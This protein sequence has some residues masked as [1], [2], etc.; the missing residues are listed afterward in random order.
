MKNISSDD[1]RAIESS[2]AFIEHIQNDIEGIKEDIEG[3][4][5]RIIEGVITRDLIPR[6]TERKEVLSQKI[7]ELQNKIGSLELSSDIEKYIE[8]MPSIIRKI[9]ELTSKPF[10]EKDFSRNYSEILKLIDITCGELTLTKEKALKI[11]LFEVLERLKEMENLNWQDD[12]L[13]LANFIENY[14]KV[15]ERYGASF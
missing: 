3:I 2:K 1:K 4:D 12:C 7:I 9:G 14:D 6:A 11:G 8:R 13:L 10:A 5:D 15:K